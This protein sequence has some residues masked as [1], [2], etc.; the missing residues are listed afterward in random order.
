M[1]ALGLAFGL[2]LLAW[3][4]A[5][6]ACSCWEPTFIVPDGVRDAPPDTKIWIAESRA[7]AL[8]YAHLRATKATERAAV[9]E[10]NLRDAIVLAGPSGEVAELGVTSLKLTG[11]GLVFVLKPRNELA[12]GAYRL[13]SRF[14]IDTEARVDF[15]ELSAE[16]EVVSTQAK[17][18]PPA[19]SARGVRWFNDEND[20]CGSAIGARVEVSPAH[21][22][23]VY[24]SVDPQ[25]PNDLERTREGYAVAEREAWIGDGP[26]SESW[27]FSRSSAVTTFGTI[28]YAGR[29]SGYGPPIRLDAPW[30]PSEL[31]TASMA[32]IRRH[33]MLSGCGCR[34]DGQRGELGDCAWLMLVVGL[35]W[36]RRRTK[37]R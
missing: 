33:S 11:L 21:W 6:L 30:T 20:Y 22:L 25:R 27:D 18:L 4:E 12:P 14:P 9:N 15:G 24:R 16:F 34:F 1:K 36:R 37:K 29:F 28:D 31:R 35:A 7:K 26:C 2:G 5:A 32:R 19:P 8:H 13:D 3:G 23:L 10:S 17:V